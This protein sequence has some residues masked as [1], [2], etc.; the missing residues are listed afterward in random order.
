MDNFKFKYGRVYYKLR[1]VLQ[2]AMDLL[3]I[4]TGITKCDDCYKLQQYNS[5]MS[6]FLVTLFLHLLLQRSAEIVLNVPRFLKQ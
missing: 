6:N 5:A 1:Q 4:A 2:S 3:Q